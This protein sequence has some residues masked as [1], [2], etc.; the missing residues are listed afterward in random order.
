MSSVSFTSLQYHDFTS[1]HDL[2]NTTTRHPDST[3]M[4]AAARK[5]VILLINI[6]GSPDV[7]AR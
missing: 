2:Q 7:R 3:D 5:I 1:L 6:Q 4:R